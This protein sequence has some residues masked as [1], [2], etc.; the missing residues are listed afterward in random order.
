M[1]KIVEESVAESSSG[2]L[3]KEKEKKKKKSGKSDE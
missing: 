1:A 3:E 2:A